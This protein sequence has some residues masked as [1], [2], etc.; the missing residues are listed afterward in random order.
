M[1]NIN[2]LVDNKEILLLK[3]LTDNKFYKHRKIVY[4]NKNFYARKNI[5]GI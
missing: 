5:Y 3:W 4:K 1:I 2:L